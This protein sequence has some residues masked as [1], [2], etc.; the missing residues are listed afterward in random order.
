[1]KVPKNFSPQMREILMA[2]LDGAAIPVPK[3]GCKDSD[4]FSFRSTRALVASGHLRVE[5]PRI[6]RGATVITDRGRALLAAVLADYVE[7]LIR[8]GL[9]VEEI[10][11]WAR[12]IDSTVRPKAAA[13]HAE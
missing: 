2:H 9:R 5:G 10:V 4:T 6:E 1:M 3:R 13:D 8:A 12:R 7:V 11:G